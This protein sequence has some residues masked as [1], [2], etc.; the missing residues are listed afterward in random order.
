MLIQRAA[1]TRRAL[2]YVN[3]VGGQD[4]LVFDGGSVAVS[5]AGEVAMRAPAFEEGLYP[6]ELR[7]RDAGVEAQTGGLAPLLPH[8]ESIYRALVLGT[9]DYVVKNHFDGVVLGLSGGVDSA[10]TLCVAVDAL[11]A[12][13]VHAVMMPSRYTSAMSLED[14]H[15]Q[16]RG[17]GVQLD[18]LSIE[19]I[20]EAHARRAARAVRGA[21]GGYDGRRISRRDA[22]ES[23]SWPSPTSSARWC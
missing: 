23:F 13:H 15:R 21:S 11:G 18:T 22:A 6:V 14:A 8:T 5:A 3:M 19:P 20:F 10:L 9:R 17:L 7:P 12:G 16:A 1:E 2:I 4:E